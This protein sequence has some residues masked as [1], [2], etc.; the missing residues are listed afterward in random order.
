MPNPNSRF[1]PHPVLIYSSAPPGYFIRSIFLLVFIGLVGGSAGAKTDIPNAP[2]VSFGPGPQFA[3]AD[4]DGDL[5]P[6]LAIVQGGQTTSGNTDYWIQ[7]HSPEPGGNP[8]DSLVPQA[9][10]KWKRAT[11]METMRLT[12]FLPPPGSDSL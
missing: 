5:H 4:F 1:G 11:S 3:I 2:I 8:F 9:D 12:W 6:D 10:Y 7:L